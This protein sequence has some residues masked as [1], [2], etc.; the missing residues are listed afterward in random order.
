MAQV[1]NHRITA[2]VLCAL[3]SGPVSLALYIV[4]HALESPPDLRFPGFGG[5]PV[6][7]ALLAMA[8]L[9]VASLPGLLA[10]WCAMN[11]LARVGWDSL[12]TSTIIGA[13]IGYLIIAGVAV[14]GVYT[15]LSDVVIISGLGA[16]LGA[17]YWAICGRK[18][19]TQRK[20]REKEQAAIRAME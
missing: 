5:W 12:A 15:D 3:A 8:K 11:W 20:A 6:S 2:I 18:E 13:V 1:R 17:L 4:N 10:F 7:R 9:S 14:L 16:I 19:R